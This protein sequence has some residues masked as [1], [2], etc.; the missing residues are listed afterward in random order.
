MYQMCI[1]HRKTFRVNQLED[2]SD[3]TTPTA[4]NNK[5]TF[6]L[7][8][9]CQRQRSPPRRP[10]EILAPPNRIHKVVMDC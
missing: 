1:M 8:L 4:I 6:T 10:W 9:Q 2:V 7:D 3:R 5:P